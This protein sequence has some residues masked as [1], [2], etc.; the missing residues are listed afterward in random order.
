M[1]KAGFQVEGKTAA[2]HAARI[3][4]EVPKFRDIIKTA[5]IKGEIGL[6]SLRVIRPAFRHYG[7]GKPAAYF[8]PACA[9]AVRSRFPAGRA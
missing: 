9:P 3:A 2:Q 5:S 7:D 4:L 1:E 8:I 6:R